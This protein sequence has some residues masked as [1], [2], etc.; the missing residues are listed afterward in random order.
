MPKIFISYSRKDEDFARQLATDL[1]RL[2]ASVWID[3]DDIPPGV[4]WSSAIQQGLDDCDTLVLVMSPDALGSTNVTDEWQYFRDEGKPIVPVICRR[5]QIVHFQLRRIQYIDF[6]EQDYEM[7]LNQLRTRLFDDDQ[8]TASRG[9]AAANLIA[10]GNTRKIDLKREMAGHRDSVLDVAFSPDNA[11]IA[12]CSEDK[13]VR[14]WYTARRKRIKMMIG[15][16]KQVNDVEFSPSGTFLASA[17]DDRSIRL[18]HTG[19]RYCITAL[20]GH[21]GAVTGL[22]Y[23][24]SDNLLASASEDATIRLWD[25]KA[26]KALATVGTHEAPANDVAFSPD[27][28]LLA[29]AGM[30]QTVRLWDVAERAEGRE[31]AAISLSDHARRIKFSPDGRYLAL[32]LNGSGLWLIDVESRAKIGSVYYADYNSSCVR[33]VAFSPDSEILA[34]ASLDGAIRLWKVEALASG[35]QGRALRV[36]SGHESGLTGVDFSTDGTLL[37]SGSHDTTAR[38]WGVVK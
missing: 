23:S 5:T 19:K 24:P 3:V 28:T 25:A 1:D 33:G 15:H 14:L 38:L 11:L 8:P 9:K 34:M 2:G 21:T 30:D 37:A 10:L 22:A 35:K 27:G 4:N 7:G 6:A 29:S 20:Y 13:S 36:L 31:L 16:E 18:W 26:Q 12:S 17:S 32:A